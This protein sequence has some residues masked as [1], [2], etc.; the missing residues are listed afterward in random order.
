[1]RYHGA[2]REQHPER[3]NVDLTPITQLLIEEG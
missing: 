3:S 1:L 2:D